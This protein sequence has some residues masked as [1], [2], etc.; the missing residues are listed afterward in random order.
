MT[1]IIGRR[2][3]L[4]GLLVAVFG[5][6]LGLWASAGTARAVT[7]PL[8]ITKTAVEVNH[9]FPGQPAEYDIHICNP[10][11]ATVDLNNLTDTLPSGFSYN[12]GSYGG[13]VTFDP[14]SNG[15]TLTWAFDGQNVTGLAC[16]DATFFVTISADEALG[17]YCNTAT[18]DWYT[19]T[20]ST[21]NASTGPTAPIQVLNEGD[22]PSTLLLAVATAMVIGGVGAA[23]Y[24]ARRR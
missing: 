5:V 16:A 4:L 1:H 3:R 8:T 21:A 10:N 2:I 17:M 13:L 11:D 7:A 19:D 12:S 22:T 9:R 24:G 20:A 18:V 6:G 23:A 15:Q 14:Q